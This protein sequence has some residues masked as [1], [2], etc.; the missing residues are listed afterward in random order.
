LLPLRGLIAAPVLPTPNR[1]HCPLLHPMV[2]PQQLQ[3]M[4]HCFSIQTPQ[5]LGAIS[6]GEMDGVNSLLDSVC[7]S[8]TE[9]ISA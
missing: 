8:V 5:A 6:G 7:S 4:L 1:H 3:C 2:N 9:G